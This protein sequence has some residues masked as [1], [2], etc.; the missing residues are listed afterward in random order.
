MTGGDI[1]TR[2]YSPAPKKEDKNI[3]MYIYFKRLV[4]KPLTFI[5]GKKLRWFILYL[6]LTQNFLDNFFYANVR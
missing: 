5:Y 6:I 4:A 1:T 2:K 3:Y